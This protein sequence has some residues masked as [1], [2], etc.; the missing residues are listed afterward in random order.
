MVFFI[1]VYLNSYVY[2]DGKNTAKSSHSLRSETDQP[3]PG[4]LWL[5]Q[6]GG[7]ISITRGGHT[8]WQAP[9]PTHFSFTTLGK[10]I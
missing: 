6:D 2:C 7:T 1:R 4:K 8:T 3:L 10:M 9:Q 5:N